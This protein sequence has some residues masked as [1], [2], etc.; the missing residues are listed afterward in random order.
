[1]GLIN[2]FNNIYEIAKF[3]SQIIH[4]NFYVFSKS[5]QIIKMNS[6]YLSI[7]LFAA[8][9]A[10]VQVSEAV[11]C[12]ECNSNTDKS[13]KDPFQASEDLLTECD[14]GETFCRKTTQTVDGKSSVYRQ[15][16]KELYRPDFVGCYSTA[17]K[18][19]TYVCTCDAAGGAC[20]EA[21]A[22][23]SSVVAI[24]LSLVLAGLLKF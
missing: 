4:L 7:L 3:L 19:S 9:M 20:N 6:F 24:S 12:Y 5:N 16:A 13:C 18:S 14:D 1:M 8:I 21:G 15:C 22:F 11:K 10:N 2:I 23:K 17:G